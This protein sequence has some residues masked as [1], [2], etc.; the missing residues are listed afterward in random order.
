MPKSSRA[1]WP[2]APRQVNTSPL[3]QLSSGLFFLSP[4][5]VVLT[6]VFSSLCDPSPW[7][8][9]AKDNRRDKCQSEAHEVFNG[10]SF[11]RERWP[12][13]IFTILFLHQRG[14]VIVCT[15]PFQRHALWNALADASPLSLCWSEMFCHI[16]CHQPFNSSRNFCFQDFFYLSQVPENVF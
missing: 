4:Y 11:R 7:D 13:S 12:I 15:E 16:T 1:R 9:A 2:R 14:S 5:S 3:I 10:R 8:W 6:S